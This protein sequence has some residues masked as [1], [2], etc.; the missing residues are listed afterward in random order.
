MTTIINPKPTELPPHKVLIT[1]EQI[2]KR[3]KELGR[4]LSQKFMGRPVV[5]ITVLNGAFVFAADLVRSLEL[6][7]HCEF[8]C[9]SSYDG[10]TKSSGQVVSTLDV[11]GNLE[12]RHLLI[13]E[14]IIDTGGT[15]ALF[16]KMMLCRKPASITTCSLLQKTKNRT[17]QCQLDYV[18]FTYKDE[19]V[20]G[21]GLDY[22]R[23]MRN[24]PYVATLEC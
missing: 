12:G 13:I 14:D 10:T 15:M 9:F 17:T 23:L 24:L 16:Q 8:V 20:V 19:F 5:V 7:V 11:P 21:Y 18:G 3:V 6:D 4:E 22:Q 1:A 2:Q